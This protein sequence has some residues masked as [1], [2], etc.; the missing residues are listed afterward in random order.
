MSVATGAVP[1]TLETVLTVTG[2]H[3]Q[4]Q[5]AKEASFYDQRRDNYLTQNA[6]TETSDLADLD[7]LLFLELMSFRW[8]TWLSSGKDYDGDPLSV[9]AEEAVRKNLKESSPLISQVKADLGLTKSIRDKEKADSVGGYLVEL[10]KRAKQ[11][12]IHRENQ[13]DVALTLFNELSSIVTT[14]D[15][16]NELERQKTGFETEADIVDW[17]RSLALPRYAAVDEHFRNRPDGQRYWVGTL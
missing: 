12:G 10:K 9:G 5:G 6:F 2:E 4:V 1:Y 3:L 17:I 14:F 8:M 7:R 16:S 11:L 13:L 15:R